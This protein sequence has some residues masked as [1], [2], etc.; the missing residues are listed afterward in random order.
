MAAT[1]LLLCPG[2][3][4]STLYASQNKDG[5]Y[6]QLMRGQVP[7]W[8]EPVPMPGSLRAR[9]CSSSGGS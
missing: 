6:M 9:A 4:E 7:A 3:S 8:L 1:L 2:M 5:F